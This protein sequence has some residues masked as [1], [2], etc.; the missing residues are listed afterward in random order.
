M[1][2]GPSRRKVLFDEPHGEDSAFAA[3]MRGEATVGE[4]LAHMRAARGLE[5][6]DVA[7][8]LRIREPFLAAIES[9][10]LSRLPGP[11]YAIGFIR[12][13]ANFLDLN[14][15]EAVRLFKNERD[16]E[17]GKAELVFPEPV[18][19]SRIPKGAILF[20]SVLLAATAYGGWY[21][22]TSRDMTLAD[23]VPE[24]PSNLG[25][26]QGDRT[27]AP[28][29]AGV[30][31]VPPAAQDAAKASATPSA[32][33]PVAAPTE[34]SKAAAVP[35]ASAPAVTGAA[36]QKAPAETASAAPP[37]TAKAAPEADKQPAPEKK[38]EAPAA[39]APEKVPAQMASAMPKAEIKPPSKPAEIAAATPPAAE[40]AE[41]K[42]PAPMPATAPEQA[43]AAPAP[44][45]EKAEKKEPAPATRTASLST[46]I[47]LRAKADSWIQIRGPGGRVVLMR[48]LR[49]GDT[50]KVPE[51][52]GLTLMTGN[53]GAIEITV[54]GKPVPAIGPYGAVRRDVALDA[55]RLRAG[56]AVAR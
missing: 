33:P 41:K 16:G 50:Y 43:S 31:V 40:K 42:E 52:K 38:A 7:N 29:T 36:P 1:S 9:G 26:E 48:I 19:E 47:E 46:E 21:Y 51:E 25:G 56:T 15:E 44:T 27:G 45:A 17:G 4:V 24:V 54:D 6:A 18:A 10:D 53:A 20:L 30:P 13:Y 32:T 3:A 11:T 28:V 23:L 5:L 35:A 55:A 14:G 39:A 49:T 8:H 22:L 2:D 34:E 37:E 12:S